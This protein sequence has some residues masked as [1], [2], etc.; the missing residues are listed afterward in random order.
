M[1]SDR[2][3]TWVCILIG[4]LYVKALGSYA[5]I[6]IIGVGIYM[7]LQK[8]KVVDNVLSVEP[9]C[10]SEIE[11]EL[12]VTENLNIDGFS[13]F[14]YVQTTLHHI[15]TYLPCITYYF[16]YN[17]YGDQIYQNVS[18]EGKNIVIK[19]DVNCSFAASKLTKLDG[20]A[21]SI[22]LTVGQKVLW[23]GI[24]GN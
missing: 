2:A 17:R 1:I 20:T 24:Q 15:D 14:R 21:V 23:R 19:N 9:P 12:N 5:L 7:C 3:Y 13:S 18:K 11:N 4:S 22:D 6:P 8:Q 10:E 16:Y